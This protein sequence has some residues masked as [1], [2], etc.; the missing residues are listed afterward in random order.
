VT[1]KT[2]P[3]LTSDQSI[4][5][6]SGLRAPAH[7]RAWV[8]E[9]VA[10]LSGDLVDNALLVVSELVT[11]AVRHGGTGIVVSLRH[12]SHGVRI[13]VADAGEALP[14]PPDAQPR[15][16][17]PHGRG[18]LI[19]AATAADWGVVPNDPPPGKTVWADVVLQD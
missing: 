15:P 6:T 11:N 4:A 13:A 14:T 12:L 10:T 18:L 2:A 16:D 19:V 1:R 9:H 7:A 5:L 3:V 17:A 8:S